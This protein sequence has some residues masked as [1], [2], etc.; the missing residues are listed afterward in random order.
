MRVS[1]PKHSIFSFEA[2]HGD[3]RQIGRSIASEI[4]QLLLTRRRLGA[5]GAKEKQPELAF[6]RCR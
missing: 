4:R 1:L 5:G 6:P 2:G 3:E